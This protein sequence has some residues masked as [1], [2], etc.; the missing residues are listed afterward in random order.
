MTPI[1][2]QLPRP[3]TPRFVKWTA[4][5]VVEQVRILFMRKFKVGDRMARFGDRVVIA[6]FPVLVGLL[7]FS[8]FAWWTW[9]SFRS[10]SE[11]HVSTLFAVFAWVFLTWLSLGVLP[12]FGMLLA[13]KTAP[14]IARWAGTRWPFPPPPKGT[15]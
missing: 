3:G 11:R 8:V 5:F 9:D 7:P 4:R 13:S 12:F 2:D 14:T 6:W 1:V 10:W 15:E